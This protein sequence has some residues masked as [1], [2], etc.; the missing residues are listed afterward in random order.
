MLIRYQDTYSRREGRWRIDER[1]LVTDWTEVR[2]A[3]RP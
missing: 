2:T 3:N 1:R